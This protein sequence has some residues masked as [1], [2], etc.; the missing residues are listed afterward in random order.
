MYVGCES[1]DDE[2]LKRIGKGETQESSVAALRKLHAAGLKT[3][4]MIL[5]GLG[6]KALSEKHVS[7]SA[8][9]IRQAPPNYLSTLVVSFPRGAARHEAGFLEDDGAGFEPLSTSEVVA[10]QYA[11][12]AQLDGLEPPK[13][14]RGVIFR[15]DHASN[16]LPLK[17]NLPRDRQRLLTLLGEAQERGPCALAARVGAWA[18]SD[19]VERSNR[20]I[21]A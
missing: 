2:V 3:S 16:Y 9:L 5:H 8:E 6:G 7:G 14:S 10:E 17:G 4:V 13:G 1:G 18:V 15:S 12:L 20:R 19:E 21:V 11:L